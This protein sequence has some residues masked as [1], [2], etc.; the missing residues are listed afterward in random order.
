MAVDYQPYVDVVNDLITER[1]GTVVLAFLLVTGLFAIGLG[2][3]STSAGT[4][5]FAQDI[6]EEQ[7]FQEVNQKFSPTFDGSTGSTQLIQRSENVLSRTELLRMLRAQER[8]TDRSGLRVSS[9]SSAA[10]IVAQQ[11]D[12]KATT[13]EAQRRAVEGATETEIKEAVR[14]ADE[15]NPRFSGLLSKDYNRRSASASATIGVVTHDL[16]VETGSGA[17]QGGS[18]PLTP[19]QQE[20]TNVV[21]SV[22]GDIR[23]FG[24]GIIAEEF[25]A[26][27][28][29]TLAIVV[30]AAVVFITFFL[31]VAY[32][33][34]ADLAL[35]VV[36][37]LM[38]LIW[39]FG[40]MGLAG[41][42]FSQILITVP[43]LL[44]AV[45]IDFGIHAVNRYREERVQGIGIDDAMRTATDQVIVAFF[46]VTGTTV[47]GFAANLTSQL[48]PIRE[49]G[50]VAAIGIVFTF[51]IFGI[52]LPAAKVK[53][54]HAREAY[55]IPTISETPFG[56]GESRLSAVQGLGVGVARVAP[57]VFIGALLLTSGVTAVYAT[58][59]STTF[60]NE[61]F[62][63][64]EEVPE[65]Y[66]YAP[67]QIQPRDY[68]VTTTLNFLQRNFES[69]QGD[70]TTVYIEGQLREDSALESIHRAGDDP[71]ETFV[72][73][74]GRADE[75][76]IVTVIQDHAER[77]PEFRRLVERNDVS[78]NGIP[79]R[80][81]GAIY[82]YL[83]D[84]PARGQALQY[85]TE[86]LRST[87]VVYAVESDAAQSDVTDDTRAVADRYRYDATATGNTVVFQAISNLIL[88][89]ALVSLVVAL[90]GTAVFLVFMYWL[91]IGRASL[92]IANIV[93]VAI[94][95][96]A[97]AG[98][99]R[100]FGLSFNAFSA[101]ILAITIGLGI[102]YSVHI[103]HRFADEYEELGRDVYESLERTVQGTGGALTVSMLT[104]VFGIGVL[105]LSL[106]P[107]IG[108]F[109]LLTALSVFYSYLASLYVLPS[110]LVIWSWV[111][112]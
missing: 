108:Q 15:R 11:L 89:S 40:F 97:I 51:L 20:A 56:G 28:G 83:L 110:V 19:I 100:A 26:V 71:P 36:S 76:S 72:R 54:D 55:P 78:D 61:D 105:M 13:P 31:L 95:V 4:G 106:F 87:R 111:A 94:T 81:L 30:P 66:D 25:G 42:P 22:G 18:S 112:G 3:V 62:L 92:G 64:P 39:T 47:I 82:E 33:D 37:L 70:T 58:G 85:I 5:Q 107:A 104:T 7:A 35:G 24:A 67:E 17:G 27:I 84:S 86:D 29:D 50:T 48:V 16:S 9:T 103:T 69:G 98:S 23:V 45:G 90:S 53:L 38:G 65:Y 41:I 6:P 46:I 60:D 75:T 102:D 79:D 80:N 73:S 68:S 91:L 1:P 59:V 74:D 109:G 99:M 52:F 14:R 49:F 96:T 88:G 2:G 57:A 101:T 32:R 77:D 21:N 44:L 12:P 93:P 63:P 34:L 10:S 43:P 8:L